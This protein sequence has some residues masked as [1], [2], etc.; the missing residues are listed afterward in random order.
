MGVQTL[1]TAIEIPPAQL[2]TC[3]VLPLPFVT[4]QFLDTGEL[5][6]WA[7]SSRKTLPCVPQVCEHVHAV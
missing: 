2:T 5:L 1:L 4:G 3:L 7:L 6:Q